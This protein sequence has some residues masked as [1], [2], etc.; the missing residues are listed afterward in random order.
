MPLGLVAM[1]ESGLWYLCMRRQSQLCMDPM[2]LY[3]K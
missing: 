1:V 2:Q 3:M